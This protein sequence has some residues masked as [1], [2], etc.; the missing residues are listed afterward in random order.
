MAVSFLSLLAKAKG[1]Q[2]LEGAKKK[3]MIKTE[4]TRTLSNF[5]FQWSKILF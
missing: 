3:K 1:L 4:S 2:F 5:D